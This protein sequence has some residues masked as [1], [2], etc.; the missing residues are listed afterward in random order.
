METSNSEV[1]EAARCGIAS[2]PFRKDKSLRPYS[3]LSAQ[4]GD[5]H[6]HSSLKH[7]RGNKRKGVI[8]SNQQLLSVSGSV[9]TT[10]KHLTETRRR[11]YSASPAVSVPI[12]RLANNQLK[13]LHYDSQ[14]PEE[15]ITPISTPSIIEDHHGVEPEL[16][17]DLLSIDPEET[18]ADH[19]QSIRPI[20]KYQHTGSN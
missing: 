8:P 6:T 3:S 15:P 1:L 20:N 12:T 7:L 17:D 4:Q 18:F 11:P 16:S 2:R 10:G 5:E 14:L 13:L 9:L 19:V